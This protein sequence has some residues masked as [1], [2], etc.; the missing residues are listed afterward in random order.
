[1]KVKDFVPIG[2]LLKTGSCGRRQPFGILFYMVSRSENPSRSVF[3]EH[4]ALSENPA[5][6]TGRDF[7]AF[8]V[9]FLSKLILNAQY[10]R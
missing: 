10:Y 2:N 8:M 4:P 3:M 5:R 9:K 1:M 7:H 6:I